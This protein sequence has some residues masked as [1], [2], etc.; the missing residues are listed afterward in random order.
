MFRSTQQDVSFYREGTEPRTEPPMYV[1]IC[2]KLQQ[3]VSFYREGTEPPM[4][5]SARYPRTTAHVSICQTW[6]LGPFIEKVRNHPCLGPFIEKVQ[7]RPCFDLPVT[8][9]QIRAPFDSEKISLTT[10]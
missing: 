2:Q 4:F 8:R 3:D 6:Q 9:A 1:S 10:R 5:R 7:N